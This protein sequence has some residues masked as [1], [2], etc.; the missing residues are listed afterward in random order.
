[1]RSKLKAMESQAGEGFV[2]CGDMGTAVGVEGDRVVNVRANM[3][4]A[5]RDTT[6]EALEG[7]R[8][9]RS[10][11]GHTKPLEEALRSAER[12]EVDRRPTG[13]RPEES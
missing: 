11:H 3:G 9:A 6:H 10:S 13:S 1:M 4:R 12:C 5:F 2:D 7:S 8:G